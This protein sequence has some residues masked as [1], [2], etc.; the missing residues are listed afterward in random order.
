MN[1]NS[2]VPNMHRIACFALEEF[3]TAK[4]AFEKAQEL[5]P[6]DST[7][8]WIRKCNA[9]LDYEEMEISPTVEKPKQEPPAQPERK[10]P[11]SQQLKQEPPTQSEENPTFQPPAQ[12]SQ[13]TKTHSTPSIPK[14]RFECL[15]TLFII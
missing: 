11:I 3:E 7:K 12:P 14:I 10:Q 15:S 8:T 5:E 6:A 4:E 13:P 2:F 9:E 1:C